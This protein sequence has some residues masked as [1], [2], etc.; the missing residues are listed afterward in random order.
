MLLVQ[1]VVN[2]CPQPILLT[3]FLGHTDLKSCG[4]GRS[5]C[6]GA[7]TVTLFPSISKCTRPPISVP[8][9]GLGLLMTVGDWGKWLPW[10]P[11][12]SS[13]GKRLWSSNINRR[14]GWMGLAALLGFAV[15][16][17]MGCHMFLQLAPNL[18]SPAL[19]DVY[20]VVHKYFLVWWKIS[21][22]GNIQGIL[23]P[24]LWN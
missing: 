21:T 22:K 15:L 7:F 6:S 3:S 24:M 9:S 1:W 10:T 5:K 8:F 19:W 2:S 23:H 4:P 16:A 20:C 11:G 13:T 17:L 14:A 12:G 18:I